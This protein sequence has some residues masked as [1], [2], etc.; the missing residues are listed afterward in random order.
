M[1]WLRMGLRAA[2]FWGLKSL[3]IVSLARGNPRLLFQGKF[4]SNLA[5]WSSNFCKPLPKGGL[6]DR[7][8]RE[9]SGGVVDNS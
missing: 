6:R 4:G 9:R 3:E 1:V 5:I 8:I 7:L 2:D